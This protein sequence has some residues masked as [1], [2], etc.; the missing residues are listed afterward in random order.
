M[1]SAFFFFLL[2]QTAPRREFFQSTEIRPA[3]PPDWP[4]SYPFLYDLRCSR[5]RVSVL[6]L[7]LLRASFGRYCFHPPFPFPR[8][9]RSTLFDAFSP[10][11]RMCQ[12]L[13]GNNIR[14][15]FPSRP[16]FPPLWNHHAPFPTAGGYLVLSGQRD[17]FSPARA[18]KP[19][20]S[21]LSVDLIVRKKK[22]DPPL[23]RLQ[24]FL[25]L[26]HFLWRLFLRSPPK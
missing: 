14:F 24:P 23:F 18:H 12:V 4:S 26:A 19:C 1:T 13:Q 15:F 10:F 16:F 20:L 25:A 17:F 22:A 21:S 7:F 3:T 6:Y 8:P 5:P 11:S 9:P 2:E